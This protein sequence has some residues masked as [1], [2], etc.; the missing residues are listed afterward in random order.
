MKEIEEPLKGAP[1]AGVLFNQGVA[2][3][4]YAMNRDALCLSEIRMEWKRPG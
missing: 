2:E 3:V 1:Y 4:G